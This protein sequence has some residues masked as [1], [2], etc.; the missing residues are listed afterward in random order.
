[1]TIADSMK[2]AAVTVLKVGVASAGT[3]L[4]FNAAKSNIAVDPI[5]HD[6]GLLMGIALLY[7]IAKALYDW[8]TSKKDNEPV[9][10]P[11]WSQQG[12]GNIQ[13]PYGLP[14][15]PPMGSSPHGG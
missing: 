4:L 10:N 1:M 15:F 14:S 3:S 9:K 11:K 8:K 6:M 2:S 12:A 7:L 13:N 5:M